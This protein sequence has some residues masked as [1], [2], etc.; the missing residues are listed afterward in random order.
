M[1][2]ADAIRNMTDDELCVFIRRM[3]LAGKRENGFDFCNY[4]LETWISQENA[5]RNSLEKP[6]GSKE[7]V[8]I[9]AEKFK[10]VFGLYATELWAMSEAYFLK[11]LNDEY[12]KDKP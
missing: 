8:M 5:D 1:T 6:N 10:E 11:W 2:N 4:N 7:R 3:Y 12:R 9:N